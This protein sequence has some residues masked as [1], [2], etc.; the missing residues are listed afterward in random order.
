VKIDPIK[1]FSKVTLETAKLHAKTLRDP[2]DAATLCHTRGA[3]HYHS[4]LFALFL[5]NMMTPSFA[6]LIHSRVDQITVWMA[7]YCSSQCAITSTGIMSIKHKIHLST[8]GLITRMMSVYLRFL[9]DNL[10]IITSTGDADNIHNDLLPHIFM[11]LQLTTIPLFQ[12]RVLTWQPKY[13]ENSLQLLAMTLITMAD[14]ECQI[15]KHSNQWVET[16]DPTIVAMKALLQGTENEI[17]R[18]YMSN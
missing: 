1:D 13:M 5:H 16:I 9:Q 15:L 7:H 4:R 10:S 17:Q 14:E 12:Q 6:A 11:Q 2:P 3:N 8:L 18:P